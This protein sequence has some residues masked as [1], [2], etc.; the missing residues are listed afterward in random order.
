MKIAIKIELEKNMSNTKIVFFLLSIVCVSQQ[1]K[2]E[3]TCSDVQLKLED[4]SKSVLTMCESLPL[5]VTWTSVPMTTIVISNL[6]D[7]G[8]KSYDIPS[9][10]PSSA[11]EVLLLASAE[12]GYSEPKGQSHYIKIYT[13]Q[14]GQTFEKY[15]YIKTYPQDAQSTNSD[16]LWFPMTT[17]C[18]VYVSVTYAHTRQV[19]FYLHAIGYR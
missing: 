13:Q 3:G 17:D 16:N 19:T 2:D 11:R 9:V 1:Q 8:T 10:I 5:V 14:D 6:Q 7:T 12:V 4:L 15:L 18:K